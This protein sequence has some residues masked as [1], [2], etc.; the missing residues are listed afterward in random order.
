LCASRS[1]LLQ[2]DGSLLQFLPPVSEQSKTDFGVGRPFPPPQLTVTVSSEQQRRMGRSTEV[3]WYW[4][5]EAATQLRRLV[6]AWSGSV[7]DLWWTKSYYGQDFGRVFRFP[8]PILIHLIFKTR[9]N[10]IHEAFQILCVC[11]Y[12]TK[13][14]RQQAQL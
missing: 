7:W 9:Y 8:L 13:L 10:H 3:P 4:R 5:Y 14:C 6:A 12:V 2:Q 1:S 11:D